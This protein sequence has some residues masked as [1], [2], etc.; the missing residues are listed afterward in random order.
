MGK[1]SLFCFLV[2]EA[3]SPNLPCGQRG[4]S[5]ELKR[6]GTV[7]LVV[8]RYKL[9]F[10]RRCDGGMP[11]SIAR[12]AVCHGARA[13][14]GKAM[15]INTAKPIYRDPDCS[16][17]TNPCSHPLATAWVDNC[18]GIGNGPGGPGSAAEFYAD[19]KARQ[20][21]HRKFYR[22]Q[23]NMVPGR[24]VFT[25]QVRWNGFAEPIPNPVF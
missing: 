5:P 3:C 18:F 4:V 7:R 1:P 24:R 13:Q 8:N 21:P 22:R 19:E 16:Q 6:E 20:A 10:Q 12:I 14:Q 23:T 9:R 11:S 2:P 17:K 15:G 25:L